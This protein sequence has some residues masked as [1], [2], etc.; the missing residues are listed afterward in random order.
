MRNFLK[1][2]S[3]QAELADADLDVVLVQEP[4]HARLAVVGR[5]H[6]DPQVELLVAGGDLDAAVLAAAAFGDVHLGQNL[7]AGEQGPQQPPRGAVALD[8]HAVDPVA[9]PHPVLERLD[10]DVRRPQ[11][12]RLADHQLHEPHDR[13]ARF[14]DILAAAA[15]ACLLRSR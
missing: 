12:H 8:Q 6:A 2:S 3:R 5:Q 9:N 13:G 11:L 1:S 7:D 14:V 10:V 15:A 4:H